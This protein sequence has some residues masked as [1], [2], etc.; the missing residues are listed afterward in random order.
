MNPGLHGE[1]PATN[2]LSHGTTLSFWRYILVKN[3]AV[4]HMTAVGC[5]VMRDVRELMKSRLSQS[6]SL[7]MFFFAHA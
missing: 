3:A 2:N 4:L 5:M 7:Q 6:S 1:R